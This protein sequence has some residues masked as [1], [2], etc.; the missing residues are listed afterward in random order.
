MRP[1]HLLTGADLPPDMESPEERFFQYP[2]LDPEEQRLV[3]EYVAANPAQASVFEQLRMLGELFQRLEQDHVAG[4]SDELLSYYVIRRHLSGDPGSSELTAIFDRVEMA[5]RDNPGVYERYQQMVIRLE[6]ITS[7]SEASPE[8][9][10]RLNRQVGGSEGDG[11]DD[12]NE[13]VRSGIM[14][15]SRGWQSPLRVAASIAIVA[16][17]GYG[18][19]SIVS[20]QTRPASERLVALE[21]LAATG[22]SFARVTRS[23]QSYDPGHVYASAMKDIEAARRSVAGLFPHYDREGLNAARDKLRTVVRDA[24][25]DSYLQMQGYF[26]LGKLAVALEDKEGARDALIRVAEADS[27]AWPEAPVL[28]RLLDSG[29]L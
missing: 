27:L 17:L 1:Y 7:Q 25:P 13:D 10:Y 18:S 19:L 3:D 20:E 8:H 5:I 16:G 14:P 26:A 4:P 12:E 2:R 21:K 22:P 29:N 6:Q 9:M 11:S 24:E 15:I 23:G 28:L